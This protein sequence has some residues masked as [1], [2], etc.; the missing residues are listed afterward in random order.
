MNFLFLL[1]IIFSFTLTIH[2]QV[3]STALQ[4]NLYDVLEDATTD[5][6]GVEYYDLVEYLMQNKIAVNTASIA[7]LMKIPNIDRQSAIAIV[8]QRNL[9][10]GIKNEN[11]LRSVEGVSEEL[12]DRIIPYLIFGD[13]KDVSFFDSI[14]KSFKAIDFTLRSRGIYD[15]QQDKAFSDGKYYG[16]SWKIYNRFVV[17]KDNNIRVGVLAEKD[18]GEKSFNDFTTFHFYARDISFIKNFVAGDFLFEFGHGLA[19]WSRYSI[20]KGIETVGILPRN[21]KGIIPYL[22]PDENMFLRGA[23][24]QFSFNNINFYT[25]YSVRNLDGSIDKSTNQITSIRLDGLH[26]DSSEVAHKRIINEKLFGISADYTFGETGSVGLLYYNSTFGNDFQY[27]S[28]LDPSGSRFDYFAGNYNF[29]FGKIYLS[30]EAAYNKISLATINSAEIAVDKN[31]SLL[32]SYRNYPY[33]YW[34]LHSNGFGEKDGTQNESGFYTGFRWQTIYGK[35]N[36][37]YDQFKYPIGDEKLPLAIKGNEFLIYYSVKPFRD[38]EFRLRY[39]NQLKES[40]AALN[41]EYGVLSRRKDNLRTELLY[42]LSNFVQMRSRIE[43]VKIY[44]TTISES[45]RGLLIFQ[46]VKYAPTASLSFS[47]RIVFFQTDSYDSRVYEF[48]NDLTGVMSNPALYG[49]GMRW[50]LVARYNTSFGLSLSMKYSELIKPN[51][52]T[53]GSGDTLINSNVDNRL[54]FQLDFKF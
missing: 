51:D 52:K 28:L 46:D 15:L 41:G 4:K 42:K 9:L 3:D 19:L 43:F 24:V 10:G 33:D 5:K 31:F 54:S 17:S 39:T 36:F 29:S 49:D 40:V 7:E 13:V 45:E 27:N 20:S 50:Y 23:A 34:S 30:G 37:Y 6:E 16:S 1:I 14:N 21:G 22:S 38:T 44:T 26:R 32:F 25:F 18:P 48:E 2:S 11:D 53:M 35:F 8:R 47:G 12:I